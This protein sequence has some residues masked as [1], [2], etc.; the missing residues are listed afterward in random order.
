MKSG[1]MSRE[2]YAAE[3]AVLEKQA[4]ELEEQIGR[5]EAAERGWLERKNKIREEI[6]RR[7]K[8]I[9][10]LCML[11]LQRDGLAETGPDSA[12]MQDGRASVPDSRARLENVYLGII[13]RRMLAS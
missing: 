4:A 3:V 13:V 1:M 9:D 12:G 6:R 5:F 10:F 2:K 7:M 8:E 11:H